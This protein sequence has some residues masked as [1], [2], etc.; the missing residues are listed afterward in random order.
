M[1]TFNDLVMQFGGLPMLEGIPFSSQSKVYFVDGARGS[2]SGSG[3]F[4][5]PLNTISAAYAKCVTGQHDVVIVL[6]STS[7]VN[8][9]AAITWSKNLTHLIGVGA[10]THAAQRTR[11]VCNATDLSPFIT[12]SGYGCIFKNLYLWQGKDDVHS[13]INVSVT[14]NRNHFV[15]VH[16]AGGGH[17]TQAIDGGM[18]LQISGGSENLFERCTVG[19]DTISTGTG[20]CALSFAATGGAARN[21]WRDCLFTLYSGHAGTIF[22][23]LLGNSGIDRYQIFERCQFINLSATAMTE[24][25]AVAAG[26]DPNNKRVLLK[27]CALIGATDWDSN[28]RGVLYLNNGTITGGGNAGL[29]AVSNAT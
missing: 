9:T 25:F 5:S 1:T 12:V 21:V 26:F 28:N 16:F 29:F 11:I 8:E 24:A 13:L 17:A 15:N 3:E 23:E 18:S 7:A 22:V 4:D 10:N 6:A 27:D 14:G 2:S 20:M 19:V